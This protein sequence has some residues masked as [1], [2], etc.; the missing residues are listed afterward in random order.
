MT[1]QVQKSSNKTTLIFIIGVALLLLITFLVG[2]FLLISNLMISRDDIKSGLLAVDNISQVTVEKGTILSLTVEYKKSTGYEPFDPV[3]DTSV[4]ELV[5][6]EETYEAG[7]GLGGDNSTR[8]YFF[9]ALKEVNSTKIEA[10]IYRSWE[11]TSKMVQ[12]A[13]TISVK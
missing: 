9:K 2:A 8:T 7:Y 10:G 1:K 12:D 6:T 5:D 4:F 11:P 13:V 3:Y